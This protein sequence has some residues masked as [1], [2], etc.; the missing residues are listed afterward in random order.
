MKKSVIV[1]SVDK[2]MGADES[3][4]TVSLVWSVAAVSSNKISWCVRRHKRRMIR[5]AVSSVAPSVCQHNP[6]PI[7]IASMLHS[8]QLYGLPVYKSKK[9]APVARDTKR[10]VTEQ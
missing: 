10:Q 6:L 7:D 2:L 3:I 4:H 9:H 8:N 5:Q 1:K